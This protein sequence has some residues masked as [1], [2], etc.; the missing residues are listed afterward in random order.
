MGRGGFS[1][2]G[3]EQPALCPA[4]EAGKPGVRAG[5]SGV[6]RG[7]DFDDLL[8]LTRD[9]L[10]EAAGRA[11]RRPGGLGCRGNHRVRAGR[12]IPG[13]R[14]VQG[15]ILR[16][17]EGE[18]LF[19]GRMFVVGDVK[20]SIYRFRGAE[21]AIFGQW[22]ERVPRP[23]AGCGLTENFRSVPG[24]IHFVNALFADCFAEV[25]PTDA[26]MMVSGTAHPGAAGRV[27]A[28]GR[29]V[30]LGRAGGCADSEPA[31]RTR[32]TADQRRTLE[33]RALAGLILH[34]GSTR[35][36]RSSIADQSSL[37]RRTPATSPC[38]SAR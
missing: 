13:Y 9:L 29:R 26:P 31:T 16:L 3:R 21:P 8:V 27:P 35:A 19:R 6:R 12:R 18:S 24:V 30:P 34:S 36:G 23:R 22:R 25:D 33:A 20:Q 37:A 15:E 10:R 28:A 11:A 4:V 7:L 32:S 14:R 38:C 2:I 5:Q 17:L 1:R